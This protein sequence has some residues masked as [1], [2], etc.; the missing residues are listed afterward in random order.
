ML[1][2]VLS[3]IAF[4]MLKYIPSI[5]SFLRAFIMKLRWI[6]SKAFSVSIEMIKRFLS[7]LLFR[8]CVKFIDLLMWNYPYIPGMQ[9]TRSWWMVLLMCC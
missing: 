8:C 9:L 3:Y 5:Y 7:L 6:L 4:I 2:I 1:A